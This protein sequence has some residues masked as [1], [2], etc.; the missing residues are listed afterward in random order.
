M[1]LIGKSGTK[2]GAAVEADTDAWAESA[3]S[4]D[5]RP[6]ALPAQRTSGLSERPAAGGFG[7]DSLVHV[8]TRQFSA[9][10]FISCRS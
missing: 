3:E 9:A 7:P 10:V 1:R 4:P 8:S 6:G 2:S 5:N